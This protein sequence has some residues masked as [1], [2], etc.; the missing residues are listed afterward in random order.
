MKQKSKFDKTVG[1]LQEGRQILNGQASDN[2]GN[3]YRRRML[4]DRLNADNLTQQTDAV[5]SYQQPIPQQPIKNDKS[6][7]WYYYNQ[8]STPERMPEGFIQNLTDNGGTQSVA[9]PAFNKPYT[10]YQDPVEKQQKVDLYNY[11]HNEA[12]KQELN[13]KGIEGLINGL[14][15]LN[16]IDPLAYVSAAIGNPDKPEN[17]FADNMLQGY[18][19]PRLLA[20]GLFLPFGKQPLISRL[21]SK[22][23]QVP[24]SLMWKAIYAFDAHAPIA[25][26]S[27]I[28]KPYRMKRAEQGRQE[29]LNFIQSPEYK[30]RWKSAGISDNDAD[31]IIKEMANEAR[32][33]PFDF[34]KSLSKLGAAGVVSPNPPITSFL[35]INGK[36]LEIYNADT[37]TKGVSIAP[38]STKDSKET[39]IHELLHFTTDNATALDYNSHYLR[40]SKNL[41]ENVA[42]DF[43]TSTS[44][45]R[46]IL[47]PRGKKWQHFIVNR[48]NDLLP[49]KQPL[50]EMIMTDEN[51]AKN[52]FIRQG[53][54][55]NEAAKEVKNIKNDIEYMW[56]DQEQRAH[57]L[58]WFIDD[59]KPNI[60]NPNDAKEIEEYLIKNPMVLNNAPDGVREVMY[61]LRPGSVKDYA[62][63]FA[64]A[65]STVPLINLVNNNGR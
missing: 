9:Q 47:I 42:Y 53:K 45:R 8:F 28:Y 10:G 31:K 2:N 36:P 50:Y 48:S 63:Y 41:F 3:S 7:Y 25:I 11:Q 4:S 54:S 56:D 18:Y 62:S 32:Q 60:K 1:Y 35:T 5:Q 13:Q 39:A 29:F 15:A 64:K 58:S 21:F 59:I 24:N 55:P 65:L 26:K 61:R 38:Y 30:E 49:P 33:V 34:S 37:G 19:D 17:T 20:A 51:A 46:L 43:P 14:Q 12:K 52:Y 57:L 40:D 6:P 27:R 16:Y 44:G 23:K 22:M